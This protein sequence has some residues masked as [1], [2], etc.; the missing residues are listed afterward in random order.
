VG[1]SLAAA[2]PMH[3]PVY[4]EHVG[5]VLPDTHV[6]HIPPPCPHSAFDV[7]GWQSDPSQQPP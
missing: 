3:I 4:T 7:P 6:V 1:Q 2:Q 5:V